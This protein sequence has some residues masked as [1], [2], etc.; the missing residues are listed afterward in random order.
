[1]SDE[2]A[3]LRDRL[4]NQL[5]PNWLAQLVMSFPVTGADFSLSEVNDESGLGA[6]MHWLTPDQIIDEATNTYPG[7]AA[8]RCRYLPVGSCLVGSGDPYFLKID[9]SGDPAIVRIPHEAAKADNDELD[10]S[11]VEIVCSS[12]AEFLKRAKLH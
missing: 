9:E 8:I 1:T 5:V 4:G 7:I 12:L 10:E 2:L 6:E 11:R 3:S